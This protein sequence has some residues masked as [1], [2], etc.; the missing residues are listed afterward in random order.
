MSSAPQ[1][2]DHPPSVPVSPH[3]LTW[4]FG[5][6]SIGGLGSGLFANQ[7]PF[8]NGVLAHPLVVLFALAAAVLL[9]LRFLHARPLTEVI[10]TL[11]VALGCVIAIVC[12]FIGDWF[13]INLMALP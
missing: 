7:H 5:F 2:P 1:S 8:G 3:I 11:A 4:W 6:M 12:F 13:G 9:S 10:S